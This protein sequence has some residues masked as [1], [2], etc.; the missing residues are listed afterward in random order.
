MSERKIINDALIQAAKAGDVG[1]IRAALANG[2]HSL[3]ALTSLG[4]KN[5]DQIDVQPWW[6][7]A[8]SPSPARLRK[9][10]CGQNLN[11]LRRCLGREIE[12]ENSSAQ[13]SAS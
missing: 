13:A 12:P 5:A 2:A 4:A 11:S 1:A 10:L 8:G 3:L 9:A 6:R 7:P